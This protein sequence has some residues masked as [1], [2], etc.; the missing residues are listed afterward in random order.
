MYL[1]NDFTGFTG[2]R[3][4]IRDDDGAEGL[5]QAP[6]LHWRRLRLALH[7]EM[8][9]RLPAERPLPPHQALIRETDFA[10]KQA[11]AFCPYSPEAVERYINFLVPQNRLDDAITVVETCLKFDPYGPMQDVLKQLEGIKQMSANRQ[12]FT[13]QLQQLTAEVEKDPTNFQS[14]LALA[15][16]YLEM[17]QT[18]RAAALLQAALPYFDEVLASSNATYANV[19]GMVQISAMLGNMPRLES[20]L[21]KLAA[22]APGQP[23]PRYDLAALDAV[24][25]R[26]SEAIQ[27]LQASL[28]LNAKRLAKDPA[29]RNLLVQVRRDPRFD[30]LRNLPAFQKLVPPQ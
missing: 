12:Q 3:K 15:Q 9:A 10:Y 16:V 14:T 8:P 23:E 11:F 13:A 29:A 2:D 25:G 21:K 27:N 18:N 24:L 4:F 20:A 30:S 22:L 26:T 19:S 6:G 17:Q 7:P 5:F 1:H 28:D